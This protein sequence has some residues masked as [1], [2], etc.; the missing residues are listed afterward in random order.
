MGEVIDLEF[1][2]ENEEAE[3]NENTEMENDP[4]KTIRNEINRLD[5]YIMELNIGFGRLMILQEYQTIILSLEKYSNMAILSAI[6]YA[7][8]N[9]EINEENKDKFIDACEDKLKIIDPE[10][11]DTDKIK[12]EDV[13]KINKFSLDVCRSHIKQQF[14]L[15]SGNYEEYTKERNGYG[16]ICV[17]LF[18]EF[19]EL[20]HKLIEERKKAFDEEIAKAIENENSESKK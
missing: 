14:Y 8:K 10:L 4:E 3:N 1:K 17:S 7:S 2:K 15:M 6:N 11:Y 5:Y 19:A 13:A 12:D 16:Q 18:N 9:F 20:K